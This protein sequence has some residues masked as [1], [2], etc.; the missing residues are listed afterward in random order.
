MLS[1]SQGEQQA[2]R[3]GNGALDH[4]GAGD[5][6]QCQ[7]VLALPHPDEHV[8]QLGHFGGHRLSSRAG[9]TGERPNSSPMPPPAGNEQLA[10]SATT[11]S[12]T[13]FAAAPC[14]APILADPA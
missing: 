13:R 1:S 9:H 14:R 6:G 7:P 3:L 5:I 4:H 12:A 11:P 2:E 10:A 8:H